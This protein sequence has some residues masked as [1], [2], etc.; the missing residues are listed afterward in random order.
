[1][2]LKTGNKKLLQSYLAINLA[3]AVSMIASI[4]EVTAG[5]LMPGAVHSFLWSVLKGNM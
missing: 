2:F 3:A 1:M 4:P 5:P